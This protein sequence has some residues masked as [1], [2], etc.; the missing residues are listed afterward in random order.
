MT[1]SKQAFG[2]FVITK[3]QA[4]GLTQREL[5]DR[6]FVTESAVSKWERGLSYPDITLVES[7]SR[8]LGVSE[9]EL[10]NASD[11]ADGRQIA[12]DALGY[13][14]WKAGIFWTTTIAYAVALVTCFIVNLA[15]GHTLSWFWIVL[16]AIA[17]AFSLTT[18]PLLRIR[19]KG[20]GTLVGFLIS[21][22]LLLFV[23]WLEGGRGGWLPIPIA[24]VLFAVV[25]VFGPFWL[26]GLA[27][28]EPVS[29]HRT[30]LAL[31]LDTV[32][33]AALLFVTTFGE[34]L[35]WLTRALP[36]AAIALV[37]PWGLALLIRYLPLAGLYRA[38]I[39]IAF[40]ALY[41]CLVLERA[42]DWITGTNQPR[43]VDFGQWHGYYIAGNV[44]T[45]VL[46][47][48]LIV[49]AILAIAAAL[50]PAH[51]T[52]PAHPELS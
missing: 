38:S 8:E 10:I 2:R 31:G 27:L 35:V 15:V 43:P 5:A 49:A 29:R 30:V 7:L 32:A 6:L 22:F 46:V 52:R 50:R 41:G 9:G 40:T 48:S 11:D 36:I 12:R 37:L 14:R 25:L 39:A 23:V 3:R 20:W 16:T 51:R 19:A 45:L 17:V 28:P 47:G 44:T 42:I 13:R 24:A 21:L 33:L 18:L 1:S 34:P 4:M 26:A